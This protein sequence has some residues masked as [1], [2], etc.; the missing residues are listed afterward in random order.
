M[1][2]EEA[3]KSSMRNP[4]TD[5]ELARRIEDRLGKGLK[6]RIGAKKKSL[7]EVRE[8]IEVEHPV[9]AKLVDFGN[10]SRGLEQNLGQV[11]GEIASLLREGKYKEA[12]SLTRR[13][14]EDGLQFSVERLVDTIRKTPKG[15]V[16]GLR[17]IM[18]PGSVDHSEA[19]NLYYPGE[20]YSKKDREDLSL[21]LIRSIGIGAN[22]SIYFEGEFRKYLMSLVNSKFSK[23]H[24]DPSDINAGSWESNCPFITLARLLIW[25]YENQE[26]R[27]K[28]KSSALLK[29]TSGVIYFVPGRDK[30]KWTAQVFPQL[31]RFVE[32]WIEN[33][34]NRKKLKEMLD[35]F[36]RISRAAYKADV[37]GSR[38]H[39]ELMYGYLEMAVKSLVETSNLSW[40]PFRKAMDVALHLCMK[41]EV[42]GVFNFV[43][44]ME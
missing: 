28:E 3:I 13:L 40:E 39:L 21:R 29:Q 42:R 11:V 20:S 18:M 19:P 41:Y 26:E 37:K 32:K 33:E 38:P 34:E 7:V 2:L 44:G 6:K 14:M 23:N 36:S 22:L 31:T 12:I 43:D 17:P 16:A 27:E 9:L 5:L 35:S 15:E 1:S 4:L 25:Y 24:L 10:L 30:E 8:L